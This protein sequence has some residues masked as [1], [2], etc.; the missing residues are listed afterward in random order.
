MAVIQTQLYAFSRYESVCEDFEGFSGSQ[1]NKYLSF[2]AAVQLICELREKLHSSEH[3]PEYDL[4]HTYYPPWISEINKQLYRYINGWKRT[5]RSRDAV[6]RTQLEVE[7]REHFCPEESQRF[8]CEFF[9]LVVQIGSITIEITP[10]QNKKHS[11]YLDDEEIWQGD[12]FE[13][14]YITRDEMRE[15]PLDWLND[16]LEPG[17]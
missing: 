15:L 9:T 2:E 14:Y 4:P 1:W 12:A 17:T 13:Q 11:I 3:E 6:D 7:E 5:L 8:I 16:R 10:D